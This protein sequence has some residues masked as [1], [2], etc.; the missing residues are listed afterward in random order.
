ME[1]EAELVNWE[2]LRKDCK[3]PANDNNNGLTFG[4][5]Y[6]QNDNIMD[7]EWFKTEEERNTSIKENNIK[8]LN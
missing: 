2:E 1:T 4:L 5:A 3:Y 7:Y 8:I 6:I